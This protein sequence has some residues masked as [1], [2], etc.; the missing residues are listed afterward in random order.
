MT[1]AHSTSLYVPAGRGILHIG[2]WNGTTPPNYPDD[3]TEVGNC[4]SLEIEPV[5]ETRPHYSSREGIRLKD[6]NPT[7]TLEYTLNFECDEISAKNLNRFFMGT[8]DAAAGSISGL[9]NVEAEYALVFVSNNPV[10]P[11]QVYYFHRMTLGP[12][13]SLQLI[14]DEYLSMTFM[15]DGL[16]DTA[17]HPSSPYFTINT[18]TTTTTSTTSSTSSTTSSTNSTTSTSSTTSSSTTTTTV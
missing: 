6:L 13:G 1:E 17:N 11:N 14:G 4:P 5:R 12:N 7:T 15:G 10:G 18:V 8:L 3:Y 16:A 2:V 9:Q